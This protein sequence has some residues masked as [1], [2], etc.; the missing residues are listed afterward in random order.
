MNAKKITILHEYDPYAH[1]SALYNQGGVLKIEEYVILSFKCIFHNLL[2]QVHHNK[3]K[4]KPFFVFIKNIWRTFFIRFVKDKY[5]IVGIA[6]YSKLMNKYEKL[7]AKNKCVYFTSFDTW[8]GSAFVYDGYNREKFE[9]IL[10]SK[11]KC[12]A[13]VTKKA[14]AS[15]DVFG[16]PSFVVYHAI[17]ADKYKPVG[18]KLLNNPLRLL[19]IGQYVKRK[20]IDFLMRFCEENKNL[21]FTLTMIGAGSLQNSVDEYCKV[22]P[23][24]KNLGF[25]SKEFLQENIKNYD[26]MILPTRKE[27]FGIVIIE[28]LASGVP[29]L[30]S[31]VTGPKEIIEDGIDGFLF[32]QNDY[33]DFSIKMKYL[34]SIDSEHYET[35]KTAAIRKAQ[36]FDESNLIKIWQQIFDVA[37]KS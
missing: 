23:R 21:N 28:A 32:N 6:P 34:F 19:Y 2:H 37:E 15:F 11:F 17:Q 3:N 5:L 27:P 8:D 1:F 36:K 4:V 31:N 35:L 13:C 12:A 9:R 18:K 14:K 29:V 30:T 10:K 26:Y 22:D 20:G 24:M 33:E 16:L 25:H 7:F